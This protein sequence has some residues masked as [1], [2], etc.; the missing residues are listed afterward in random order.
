MQHDSTAGPKLCE[1]GCGMLAPIA[2]ETNRPK[3][4]VQ[5]QAMRFVYGHSLRGVWDGRTHTPES[6]RRM[7]EVKTRERHNHWKGETVINGRRLINVGKDHPLANANGYALEHRL[8]FSTAIGRFLESHEH[9]HHINED[10]LDNRIENLLVMT[11]AQHKS[12]HMRMRRLSQEDAIT[13]VMGVRVI[14]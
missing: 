9:V 6:L 14:A 5:G 13:D 12:L 3:G 2:P 8:V 1:C 4:Y 11:K 10:P 7:S